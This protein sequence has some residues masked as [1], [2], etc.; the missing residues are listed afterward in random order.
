MAMPGEV[1]PAQLASEAAQ[2]GVELDDGQITRLLHF[3]NLLAR[4]SRVHNL[5]AITGDDSILTH[6]LLDSLA[7]VPHLRA[8]LDGRERARVLDVGSGGG[9]PAVPLAI[10]MPAVAV[11]AIDKVAKKTAFLTQVRLDLPLGNFTA[12]HARVEQWRAHE[13]FDVI[14]SRAF[15]ALDDFVRLTRHLLAP[16]GC[17][18][19][20]KGVR[21]DDELATLARE[22][23]DVRV[24]HVAKLRVPRLAAERHLVVVRPTNVVA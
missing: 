11:T 13:R 14:V 24:E 4:W 5:T 8:H 18:M 1:G 21:P 3:A 12:V 10:A 22:V 20:M 9:L 16:R 6:H 7:V 23:P 19:A 2:L 15:S 17:W